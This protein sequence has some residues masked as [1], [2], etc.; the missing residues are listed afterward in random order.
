[1]A[2]SSLGP[3]STAS[4]SSPSRRTDLPRRRRARPPARGT[5][6]VGHGG[7]LDPFAAGVLPVFLGHATRVVEYHLGDGRRIAPRSASG[8]RRRRTTSRASCT[9]PRPRRRVPRSRRRCPAD[10]TISQRPPA[11]SAIKVG[12]RRAYAMA[13][14]GET[15]ALPPRGDDPRARAR[16]WDDATPSDPS[17]SS[18]SPARPGRTCGRSRA[19]SG[20]RV[21]SRAYLGRADAHG[22]GRVR[23]R[24]ARPLDDDPSAAAARRSGRSL[25]APIDDGLDRS[26]S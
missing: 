19:T 5:K 22:I 13:R 17:R 18:T 15:V 2:R 20:E 9:P 14:A 4:S 21:G 7:T 24:D 1:M 6:R 8:A 3:G 10:R 11:Y 25:L 26:R 12:G 16:V 23:A